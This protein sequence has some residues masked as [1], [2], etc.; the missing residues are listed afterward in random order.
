MTD[1][2]PRGVRG[3]GGPLGGHVLFRWLWA[4]R[5]VSSLGDSLLLVALLLH[6]SERAGQTFAVAALLLAGDVVPALLGP[7][8][9]AVADRFDLRRVMVGCELV[10]AAAVL[11]IVLV[12]P[13]LPA[14]L[15]LVAVRGGAG[16]LSQAAARSAVPALVPDD[17]LKS[18]NAV[19]GISTNGTEAV[20]PVLAA[21][22]LP[23]VGIR[24][25]LLVG[26]ATFLVAAA[27]LTRVPAWRPRCS[28]GTTVSLS[29]DARAGLRYI[30]SVRPV[31]VIALGFLAV[32]T[33]NGVDD[34]ALVFLARGPLQASGSAVAMLYGAVGFG[35]LA[36]YALLARRAE[37]GPLVVLLLTG[38]A[39]SSL[40]NL[41]TGLAWSVA[42]AF[43]LQLARGVGLAASDVGVNTLLQRQAPPSMLGRLFATLYGAVGLAAAASYLLG[44]LLLELTGPRVTLVVAGA[45]G[46]LATALTALALWLSRAREQA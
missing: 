42:A 29:A 16:Q 41:L 7:L 45:G 39:V 43:G 11:V 19:L 28:G 33:F 22:L 21:V 36:G 2:P 13:P 46:L 1:C 18:A 34:V 44:A 9:G 17:R 32:V 4:A 12:L 8:G 27:L 24:G 15:V 3:G 30:A 40:G 6:V 37:K 35:L 14:L 23:F 5:G 10:Q 31:R 25:V 26:V 38:F 20:G